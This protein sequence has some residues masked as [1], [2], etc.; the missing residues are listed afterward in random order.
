M[1]GQP[2]AT[3]GVCGS[4]SLPRLQRSPPS[5][6]NCHARHGE[7]ANKLPNVCGASIIWRKSSALALKGCPVNSQRFS[8]NQ[9]I[10]ASFRNGPVPPPMVCTPYQTAQDPGRGGSVFYGACRNRKGGH[11]RS[12]GGEQRRG[13]SLGGCWCSHH[14]DHDY[15]TTFVPD[16]LAAILHSLSGWH[17][18]ITYLLRLPPFYTL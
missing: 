9:Q 6:R 16:A 1:V 5:Q 4:C 15:K 18:D 10:S 12:L 14:P 2:V 7:N 11:R 17:K 8:S 13:Q 3:L